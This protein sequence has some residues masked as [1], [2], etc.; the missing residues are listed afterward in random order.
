MEKKFPASGMSEKEGRKCE[1]YDSPSGILRNDKFHSI[2]NGEI[3]Q[4]LNSS[5]LAANHTTDV[6]ILVSQS[7]N[8]KYCSVN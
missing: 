1:D 8:S 5:I 7:M 4:K 3:I 2:R 6:F